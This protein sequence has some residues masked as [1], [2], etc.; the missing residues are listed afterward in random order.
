MSSE[1]EGGC[2]N[3]VFLDKARDP[4]SFESG[5]ARL[6]DFSETDAMAQTIESIEQCALRLM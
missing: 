3:S 6:F 2:F 1:V 4:Y 5:L